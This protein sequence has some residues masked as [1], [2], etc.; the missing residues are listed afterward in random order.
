MLTQFTTDVENLTNISDNPGLSAAAMKALFDKAGVDIKA[1]INSVLTV[2]LDAMRLQASRTI[3]VSP[4][5]NNTKGDGS[6]EKPYL[7]IGKAIG[8]IPKNLN[9]FIATI[10]ISPG[11]YAENVAF[12]NFYGGTITMVIA[13]TVEITSLKVHNSSVFI[14]T[15]GGEVTLQA[16]YIYTTYHAILYSTTSVTVHIYVGGTVAGLNVG[17]SAYSFSDIYIGGLCRVFATTNAAIRSEVFSSVFVG[18]VGLTDNSGYGLRAVLGGSIGY[19]ALSDGTV[20]ATSTLSGGRIYSGA[21]T[22][23]PNY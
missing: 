16:A 10:S 17:L 6:T 19:T 12:N 20:L 9:G 22:S 1:Y 3:Y 13:G 4:G 21:Q 5:G 14:D 8:V 7:T 15:Y 2:E 23:I 18:T 11:T